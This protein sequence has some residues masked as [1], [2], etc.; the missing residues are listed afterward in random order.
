MFIGYEVFGEVEMCH[1]VAAL[2]PLTR[3]FTHGTSSHTGRNPEL[4]QAK[5][6]LPLV[7]SQQQVGG[8]VRTGC[9][10]SISIADI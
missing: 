2:A 5:S 9:V 10:R 7:Y 1:Q 4:R 8:Q 6:A 3:D